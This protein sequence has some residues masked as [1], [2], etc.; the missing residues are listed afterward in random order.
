MCAFG[1]HTQLQ[2]GRLTPWC[3]SGVHTDLQP[4]RG[5]CTLTYS[6]G[7]RLRHGCAW[8][9]R[10]LGGSAATERQAELLLDVLRSSKVLCYAMSGTGIAYAAM[11]CPVQA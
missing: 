7:G 4:G 1:V 11:P 10:R 2:S 5:V 8:G 9:V 6:L 3:F